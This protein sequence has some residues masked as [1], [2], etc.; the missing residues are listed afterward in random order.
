ML[1][2]LIAALEELAP[3]HVAGTAADEDVAVQAMQPGGVACDL[4][5]VDI[6]LRSG[7]GLGVVAAARRRRPGLPVV[8]LS[9]YATDE[10]RARCLAAGADRVFDKSREIDLLVGFCTALADRGGRGGPAPH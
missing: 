9:N 5:I 6:F 4:V 2:S 3:V 1:E 8:V 7:S 10:M